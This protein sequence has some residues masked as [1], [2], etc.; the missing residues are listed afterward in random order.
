MVDEKI[1]E[2]LSKSKDADVKELLRDYMALVESPYYT[3]YV[4]LL[5]QIETWNTEIKDEPVKLANK[6][7]ED[8][9][10]FEKSHK[11]FSTINTLYNQLE[12]LRA[13]MSPEQVILAKAEATS[14]IDEVR[15]K[16]KEQLNGE[17]GK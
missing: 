4:S 12:Y 7:E 9:R 14:T 17:R 10:A 6:T 15:S 8:Q 11:Y 2:R 16:V 1:L 5:I 3:G 13:K